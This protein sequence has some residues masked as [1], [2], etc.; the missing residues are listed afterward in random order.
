MEYLSDRLKE[1]DDFYEVLAWDKLSTKSQNTLQRAIERSDVWRTSELN[2]FSFDLLSKISVEDLNDAR[3]IGPA[4]AEELMLELITLFE[5]LNVK[6]EMDT[7]ASAAS[8]LVSVSS[9][10]ILAK[11]TVEEDLFMYLE[12]IASFDKL[13]PQQRHSLLQELL[14]NK[15]PF[16]RMMFGRRDKEVALGHLIEANLRL[17][18]A[19]AKRVF[20]DQD[21][22]ART[23][24]G[25]LGLLAG[26]NSFSDKPNIDFESHV[27]KHVRVFIQELIGDLS[28]SYSDILDLMFDPSDFEVTTIQTELVT[29]V[30]IPFANCATFSELF[31]ELDRALLKLPKV[32]ER[33]IAMLKHRH[34]AFGEPGLSLDEI[35]KEWGVTRERVRQIVEPF[36]AV[37][38]QLESDPQLLLKAVEIFEECEDENEFK[39][40]VAT[41]SIFSGE[42][43]TWER[44]WGITQILSP[45]VLAN[46]VYEKHL[47]IKF[48][49]GVNSPLKGLVK[50]DRS[51]FGLYDL[52]VVARKYEVNEEKAFKII[53]E[54]YP[55]SIRSGSL[56]L[57]RTKNL[58]TMFENSIAKQLKVKSP[59]EVPILLKG[60][61]RTGRN[62][63]VAL[64]GTSEDLTNLIWS[65]AGNPPSYE[66]ISH[67]LKKDIEF[68]SIEK[69]LIGI[70][71]TSNLGILHSNDVVNFALNQGSINVS[72]V[73]VYLLNSPIIR[74]HGK[75]LF[76]L[77]GTDVAED[78]LDAYSQIIRGT[79][80]SS[81][82][83]YEMTDSS[84]GILS[85]RPNLN[86]ITSGIVFPPPGYK[87]IFQ[88]YE[89]KSSCRCGNLE[90]IQAV[91]FAPSGFWTGFTAMIRHGFSAH[92]M[93]KNSTFRFEFDFDNS[94]VHLL[95]NPYEQL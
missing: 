67:G 24:A 35:G 73:T 28:L 76:S 78:Q 79:S 81:E 90:T 91:K 36:M 53:S 94:K 52:K 29:E 5:N 50:K 30:D 31:E 93:N 12:R 15:N 48:E 43:V 32:D 1:P 6:K 55:R 80:E 44:L 18:F 71:S 83:L 88:G 70:F 89:F 61:K 72:S 68:Q 42:S 4:R 20:E 41:E 40:K 54:I 8:R 75:S 47:E 51:K 64:I 37:T 19:L 92:G 27:M 3:F 49:S 13:T 23:I 58:D 84:M 56:V 16:S 11:L 14:P 45:D 85:V 17:S 33:V 86:V 7:T 95:S 10:K 21:I 25:N 63:D 39:A 82:V 26:I 2:G 87:K 60:L 38:I 69:W 34:Q 66:E 74:S 22:R 62:R 57:A 9:L 65:L 59:L 46:R 77:V